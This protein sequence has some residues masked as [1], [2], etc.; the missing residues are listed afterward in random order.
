MSQLLIVTSDDKQTVVTFI[1]GIFSSTTQIIIGIMISIISIVCSPCIQQHICV[2]IKKGISITHGFS[3]T[4]TDTIRILPFQ[5]QIRQYFPTG[6]DVD[7]D[8]IFIIFTYAR[9]ID[10]SCG[11][12][13]HR[14]VSVISETTSFFLR[15]TSHCIRWCLIHPFK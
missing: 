13:H 5:Y 14:P 12:G 7:A 11:I 9:M 8:I 15:I 6:G 2:V 3:S 10:K 4:A 1:I